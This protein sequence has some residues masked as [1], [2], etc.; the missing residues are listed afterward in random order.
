[1]SKNRGRFDPM[2]RTYPPVVGLDADG[3]PSAP[4]TGTRGKFTSDVIVIPPVIGVE[5]LKL[6]LRIEVPANGDPQAFALAIHRAIE[7]AS[8]MDRNLGG[9]GLVK[10]SQ[11]AEDGAVVLVLESVDPIGGDERIGVIA[12][13]K[14]AQEQL[15]AK[16]DRMKGCKPERGEPSGQQ[17]AILRA[18]SRIEQVAASSERQAEQLAKNLEVNG[19]NANAREVEAATAELNAAVAHINRLHGTIDARPLK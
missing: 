12:I 18:F 5:Y 19:P 8:E 10:R 2:V 17:L 7:A 13:V 6:H 3:T 14:M 15:R 1:M 4:L 9:E 16:P 11:E